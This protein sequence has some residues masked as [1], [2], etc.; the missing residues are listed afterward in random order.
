MRH[1]VIGA[2]L[3]LT[4]LG[5]DRSADRAELAA[6]IYAIAPRGTPIED[7]KRRVVA[8]G[9]DCDTIQPFSRLGTDTIRA[10]PCL[11]QTMRGAAGAMFLL[12]VQQGRL[13]NVL[14]ERRE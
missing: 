2:A 6:R 13:D 10:I 4:I 11:N 8:A 12:V 5:C 14:V 1:V 3:V 9:F 7:A